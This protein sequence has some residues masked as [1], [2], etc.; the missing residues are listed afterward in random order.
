MEFI[1]I[2]KEGFAV[3]V[4]RDNLILSTLIHGGSGAMSSVASACPEIAVAIFDAFEKGNYEEARVQQMAFAQLR[5]LFNLGTF[6]VVIKEALRLR[7][8]DVGMPRAP[9]SGLSDAK[10]KELSECLQGMLNY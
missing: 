10:R 4:G 9:V 7:G 6:P 1:R 5:Q 2:E 3:Y 8:I